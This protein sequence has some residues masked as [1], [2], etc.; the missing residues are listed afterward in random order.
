MESDELPII[1]ERLYTCAKDTLKFTAWNGHIHSSLMSLDTTCYLTCIAVWEK[2]AAS[3]VIVNKYS[4]AIRRTH[5]ATQKPS[6]HSCCPLKWTVLLVKFYM[7]CV[8]LLVGAN[9]H[10][11]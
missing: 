11:S 10:G 1:C 7:K 8:C 6:A 2:P 3:I 4:C 5:V 9:S